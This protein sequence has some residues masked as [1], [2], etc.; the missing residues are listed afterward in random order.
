MTSGQRGSKVAIVTG[1]ARGLGWAITERLLSDGLRVAIFA[2]NPPKN[3]GGRGKEPLFL[4]I[5]V[6]NP[7]QVS[8]GVATVLEKFGRLDVL[9]NN[10]GVS[11]PVKPVQDI[12]H[13]EWQHTL[14]VN[15]TGTFV[16][17][18]YAVPHI[19]KSKTS[20]R[21]VNISSMGWKKAAA[22]RTPH[23]ASKAG[24]V[25]FTR[26]LSRELGGHG[27]TVNAISPGPIEGERIEEVAKRTAAA[28]G[29]T[30]DG[31]R[32]MMLAA[33]SLRRFAAPEEMAALVSFLVSVEGGFITGQD[34]S[35]DST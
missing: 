9:V 16:C 25:G 31:V 10:A 28:R 29:E 5:D 11:G 4:K 6:A 8:R 17:C 33:S 34:F 30:A 19:I 23:S 2:R 7:T 14:D 1:G 21:V 26:S 22:F 27:V 18:K 20:G 13:D 15:L 3:S 24:I 32:R 12:E 35:A